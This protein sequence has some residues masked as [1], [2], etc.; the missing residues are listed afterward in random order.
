MRILDENDQE[1]TQEEI[2]FE[3]GFLKEEKILIKVLPLIQHYVVLRI[4]F[5]DKT[6]YIP[7]SE[8]DPHIEIIDAEQGSFSYIPDEGDTRKIEGMSIGLVVDQEYSEEYEDILRYILYTEEELVQRGLP[9]RMTVVEE[10]AEEIGLS[11]EDL[12]LLLA[13]VLGGGDIPEDE[14]EEPEDEP[15]NPDE[16]IEPSEDELIENNIIEE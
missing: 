10:E 14:D 7:V 8:N 6:T 9:E 1:L 15:I 12:I 16:P 13:E 2:D 3:L 11:V 4:T 5:D